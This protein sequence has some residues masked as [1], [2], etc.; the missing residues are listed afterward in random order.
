METLVQQ[1]VSPISASYLGHQKSCHLLHRL[2]D[3]IVNLGMVLSLPGDKRHQLKDSG[4]DRRQSCRK[5]NEGQSDR[6]TERHGN[7]TGDRQVK[8]KQLDEGTLKGEYFPSST[9]LSVLSFRVFSECMKGCGKGQHTGHAAA[10]Q[11][12]LGEATLV[13]FSGGLLS[14]A[15]RA[16]VIIAGSNPALSV[17]PLER[18][19]RIPAAEEPLSWKLRGNTAA[20][21]PFVSPRSTNRGARGLNN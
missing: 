14:P 1:V 17:E 6:R 12:A 9:V 16:D 4:R 13:G 19:V 11:V 20:R 5:V 2:L 21:N 8:H 3:E 18:S 7:R 15:S 10:G